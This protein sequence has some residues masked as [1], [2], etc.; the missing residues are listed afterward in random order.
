MHKGI[1]LAG[2]FWL[3]VAI[4]KQA[5]GQSTNWGP[6]SLSPMTI[7]ARTDN[8]L[9]TIKSANM[10]YVYEFDLTTGKGVIAGMAAIQSQKV[11]RLEFPLVGE[12]EEFGLRRESLIANHGK[13]TTIIENQKGVFPVTKPLPTSRPLP[14]HIIEAW[15]RGNVGALFSAIGSDSNPLQRLVKTAAS[16]P[17][18]AVKAET[19][20]IP[21]GGSRVTHFRIVVSRTPQ[22][23][24]RL[25]KLF[26]EIVIADR[27]YLPVVMN[28]SVTI[29]KK[30]YK[31]SMHGTSWS[32]GPKQHYP[33]GA[34]D[35]RIS[36]IKVQEL[37][38][39]H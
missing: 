20:T 30:T 14:A 27:F 7:A 12:T 10:D 26:Y 25:G 2:L 36:H 21:V 37:T 34:F 15:M 3:F 11:F 35:Q 32:T 13:L 5:L 6:T 24:K 38:I 16:T 31:T 39:G 17:G 28:N 33:A 1:P 18:Y 23:A 22:M 4:P 9:H 29:G 19:R 8:R